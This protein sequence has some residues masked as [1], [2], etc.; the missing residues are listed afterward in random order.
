MIDTTRIIETV[1]ERI[2]KL[3]EGH[4]L[5]LRTYKRNRSIMI[6][7]KAGDEFELIEDGYY[8]ERLSIQSDKLKKT[9][10]TLLKREFPRSHRVRLYMMGTFDEE[11]STAV[12]RKIL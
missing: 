8:N 4:C 3:P 9:L 7:K 11:K 6:V 12:K 5:D 1:L 10:S 2:G